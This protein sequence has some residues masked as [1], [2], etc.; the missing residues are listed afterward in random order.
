MLA[1]LL[2]STRVARLSVFVVS[3]TSKRKFQTKLF[4]NCCF[5]L[6]SFVSKPDCFVCVLLN[7][8]KLKRI[9]TANS[10]PSFQIHC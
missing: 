7:S 4:Q 1:S 10:Q 5:T 2:N 3:R 6:K 8:N 9:Q